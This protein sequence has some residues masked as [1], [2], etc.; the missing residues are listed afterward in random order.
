V[1]QWLRAL[2]TGGF[3]VKCGRSFEV[4][5]LAVEAYVANAKKSGSVTGKNHAAARARATWITTITTTTN[6][7]DETQ[8]TENVEPHLST[9]EREPCE[10]AFVTDVVAILRHFRIVAVVELER[11]DIV[12]LG[13]LGMDLSVAWEAART[14]HRAASKR[15]D[16]FEATAEGLMAGARIAAEMPEDAEEAESPSPADSTR[17]PADPIDIRWSPKAHRGDIG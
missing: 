13:A 7:T 6:A 10:E 2:A 9:E 16:Y 17:H 5:E 12:R 14:T 3:V 15:F 4:R 8:P 11:R 1:S